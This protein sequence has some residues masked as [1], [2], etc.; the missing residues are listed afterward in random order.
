MDG[1]EHDSNP[2]LSSSQHCSTL[3]STP[4]S[5]P[6]PEPVN[7]VEPP[8]KMS[9]VFKKALST[10]HDQIRANGFTDEDIKKVQR[11]AN[12]T[13][14][15]EEDDNEEQS[16][17]NPYQERA[18]EIGISHRIPGI[19]H[20][21]NLLAP[22]GWK[23]G[24]EPITPSRARELQKGS[25][26]AA[27]LRLTHG[28][29][30]IKNLKG[31]AFQEASDV[32][33]GEWHNQINLIKL[34]CE[35]RIKVYHAYQTRKH[36]DR[37]EGQKPLLLS[38]YLQSD[39]PSPWMTYALDSASKGFTSDHPSSQSVL[40]HRPVNGFGGPEPSPKILSPSVL[41]PSLIPST[42][43]AVIQKYQTQNAVIAQLK[44]DNELQLTQC[45]TK[46]GSHLGPGNHPVQLP[47]GAPA[48]ALPHMAGANGG[49]NGYNHQGDRA[50]TGTRYAPSPSQ[51]ALGVYEDDEPVELA[52][53]S[54][55]KSLDPD[56]T[57]WPSTRD[58]IVIQSESP[59]SSK[60]STPK[61]SNS[62]K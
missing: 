6:L 15:F 29:T 62:N 58:P 22:I 51:N 11:E 26:E 27:K 10:M 9:E 50:P 44:R 13:N 21:G 35:E 57:P 7:T 45:L 61:K 31:S 1:S 25:Y 14:P 43:E 16:E 23:A 24:D 33:N 20:I 47:L 19:G 3:G 36:R 37:Q 5:E 32:K 4:A 41:D 49:A 18:D 17:F 8:M 40:V 39:A 55:L 28:I 2:E 59:E 30:E 12:L 60:Q 38:R 46:Y 53:S 54:P 52:L 34:I 48:G 56:S 42:V